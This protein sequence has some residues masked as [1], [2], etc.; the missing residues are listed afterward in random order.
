MTYFMAF[1]YYSILFHLVYRGF[2]FSFNEEYFTLLLVLLVVFS[3][4]ML[5]L[6]KSGQ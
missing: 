5:I 3:L 4:R 2:L 6:V 1:D